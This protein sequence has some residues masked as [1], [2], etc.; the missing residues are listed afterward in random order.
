MKH[1]FT[2]LAI[3]TLIVFSACNKEKLQEN[4]ETEFAVTISYDVKQTD[5]TVFP[6]N[7]LE[8]LPPDLQLSAAPVIINEKHFMGVYPDGSV[9]KEITIVSKNNK[10]YA[11]NNNKLGDYS[12]I[13]F[14]GDMIYFFDN[15]GKEIYHVKGDALN[16]S[17]LL[18]TLKDT[19]SYLKS[20]TATIEIFKKSLP[21]EVYNIQN[22][23]EDIYSYE[24]DKLLQST[25]NKSTKE[26]I[27]IVNYYDASIK[28]VVAAKEY[29]EKNEELMTYRAAFSAKPTIDELPN[30]EITELKQ[31]INGNDCKKVTINNYS[32]YKLVKNI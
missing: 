20:K 2:L 14:I 8:N 23:S 9:Y 17:D 10:G 7:E 30:T 24:Y 11:D 25:E 27:K 22:I 15:T 1:Y 26:K 32:N 21:K 12:K 6:G 29:N 31:K 16:Y 19:A 4:S 3:C 28:K 18:E 13:K 5:F